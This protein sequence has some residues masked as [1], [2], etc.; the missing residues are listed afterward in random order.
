MDTRL[1]HLREIIKSQTLEAALIT[2]IPNIFYLTGYDGFLIEER[3]AYLFITKKEAY[4]F[5]NALYLDEVT[6]AAPHII[7]KAINRYQPI[8]KALQELTTQQAI[9]KVGIEEHNLTA[10]EYK[11]LSSLPISLDAI[12]LTNL[13]TLKTPEEIGAVAK[14]CA[15]GDQAFAHIL[16]QIKVGVTEKELAYGLDLFMKQNLADPSFRSIVAFGPNAAFPH[17][18]SGDEPLEN[19]TCILMDFGVKLNN[20][21]SDMSRT[22]FI[23][24]PSQSQRK[25]YQTVLEAQQQAIEFIEHELE[26]NETITG[27]APDAIARKHIEKQGFPSYPHGLGHGIGIE[28]HESPRLSPLAKSQLKAGMVFSI[29]PGIYLAGEM[30]VRIEDLFAI[31]ANKL[32]RLTHAPSNLITV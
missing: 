23:G 22:V 25:V 21:C 6:R 5:T 14:A 17:H 28:L 10:A 27:I 19:N 29:E 12:N 18:V 3:E 30:G 32:V 2:S 7:V 4:L 11:N 20:Y 1:Q 24:K 16:T 8:A 26:E 9:K 31:Q 15:I 13:R